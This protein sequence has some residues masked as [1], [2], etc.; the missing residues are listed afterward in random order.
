MMV[1]AYAMGWFLINDRIKFLAYR[2]LIPG[3]HRNSGGDGDAP[4]CK[5]GLALCS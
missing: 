4:Q 5:A 3:T 2:I 1:W